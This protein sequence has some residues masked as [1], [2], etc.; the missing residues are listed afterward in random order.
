MS[1]SS[2][3]AIPN[4]SFS[5]PESAWPEKKVALVFYQ[6][7]FCL[8]E[9]EMSENSPVR[10]LLDKKADNLTKFNS[11]KNAMKKKENHFW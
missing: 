10:L 11:I 5:I 4:P 9:G 1:M 8:K 7:F 3:Y 2:S 6:H